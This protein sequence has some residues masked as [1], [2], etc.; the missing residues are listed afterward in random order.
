MLRCP[1][2]SAYAMNEVQFRTETLSN[3]SYSNSASSVEKYMLL[4]KMSVAE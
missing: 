4:S 1:V 3:C 2:F